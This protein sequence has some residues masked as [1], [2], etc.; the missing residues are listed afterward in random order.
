MRKQSIIKG[1]S[2]HKQALNP[3]PLY[4]DGEVIPTETTSDLAAGTGGG[5]SITAS[6]VLQNVNP[7]WSKEELNAYMDKVSHNPSTNPEGLRGWK[8]T[9]TKEWRAK[10]QDAGDLQKD[11]QVTEDIQEEMDYTGGM[12]PSTFDPNAPWAET[13]G[14]NIAANQQLTREYEAMKTME[15]SG[16]ADELNRLFGG[17]WKIG[18]FKDE[19]GNMHDNVWVNE[20]GQSPSMR[21]QQA[22]PHKR[23]GGIRHGDEI[24]GYVSTDPRTGEHSEEEIAN[25]MKQNRAFESIEDTIKRIN[26]NRERP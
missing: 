12:Y 10:Q 7:N 4:N 20:M 18:S 25:I 21:R 23:P 6:N 15:G 22:I 13:H 19:E 9:I 8:G 5:G 17:T 1:S 14:A 26:K 2:K 11:T 3:S 16:K 24:A